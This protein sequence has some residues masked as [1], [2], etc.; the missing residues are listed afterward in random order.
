MTSKGVLVIFSLVLISTIVVLSSTAADAAPTGTNL[1]ESTFASVAKNWRNHI[2][3]EQR[4]ITC[5]HL[6][7]DINQRNAHEQELSLDR[8]IGMFEDAL[9]HLGKTN[10]YILDLVQHV[11]ARH[12]EDFDRR[13]QKFSLDLVAARSQL[14]EDMTKAQANNSDLTFNSGVL[15]RILQTGFFKACK[16]ELASMAL[17]QSSAEMATQYKV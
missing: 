17:E 2:K 8:V 16:F 1:I 12:I 9:M 10:D 11:P 4:T 6:L 7:N 3:D 14:I 13:G 5:M 15:K